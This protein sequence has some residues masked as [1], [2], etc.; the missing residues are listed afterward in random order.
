[1]Y[2][3]MHT[4]VIFTLVGDE[5]RRTHA[6]TAST[7]TRDLEMRHENYKYSQALEH[8][9]TVGLSGQIRQRARSGHLIAKTASF[10]KSYSTPPLWRLETVG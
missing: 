9:C 1:M 5:N 10:E 8:T 3:S 7:P 4:Q 2:G 6:D